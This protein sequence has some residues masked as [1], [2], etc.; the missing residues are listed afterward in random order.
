MPKNAASSEWA[1]HSTSLLLARFG[2]FKPLPS[3]GSLVRQI[4]YTS[5]ISLSCFLSSRWH[6]ERTQT[7]ASV[8]GGFRE[9]RG[10][11]R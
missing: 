3:A 1:Y 9:G 7:T 8:K 10:G 6:A 4:Y 5:P 11:G 2:L